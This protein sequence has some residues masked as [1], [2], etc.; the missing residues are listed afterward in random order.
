MPDRP[1]R[2]E[3]LQ[4]AAVAGSAHAYGPRVCDRPVRTKAYP[5]AKLRANFGQPI[6]LPNTR[7]DVWTSTWADDDNL[8]CVSDDTDGFDKACHSN[9][10]VHRI[11]GTPP[12]IKGVTINSMMEYGKDGELK[13]DRASWKAC[14]LSSINGTLYLSVSRQGYGNQGSHSYSIQEC[15]DSSIIKSSDH[16]RT[17]SPAPKLNHAMFPGRTFSTPFFVHYGK[18]NA[19]SKDEADKYV[20]AISNDGGWDN[21]NWMTLGRVRRDQI[22]RLDPCDWEFVQGFEEKDVEDRNPIWG[23]RHDT[24]RCVFRAPDRAS[25]TGMHFIAGLDLYIMPQWHYTTRWSG[26]AIELHHSPTPW[27]PFT[28]FHV[29]DTTP[30]GWYNPG[31]PSKFISANGHELWFFTAGLGDLKGGNGPS[32]ET[33]KL[34]LVPVTLDVVA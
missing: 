22:G 1:T 9:L 5:N 28:L 20:Y 19:G 18:D 13:E 29:H 30:Y 6:L 3:F 2:R 32:D 15:W 17:W 21:G 8:Y 7:G 23:P 25:M 12:D 16:G 34:T 24:A 4:V 14:G 26:T 11:T 33:Y 10:A 31:I 27:G